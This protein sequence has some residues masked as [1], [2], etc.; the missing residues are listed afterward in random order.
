[1]GGGVY[2][3]GEIV[4]RIED[5]NMKRIR[6]TP[7]RDCILVFLVWT[8]KAHPSSSRSQWNLYPTLSTQAAS[9]QSTTYLAIPLIFPASQQISCNPI[10]L[11]RA[12]SKGPNKDADTKLIAM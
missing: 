2:S 3:E 9:Q 7:R 12:L 5:D 1:M 11:P 4:K 6:F 8:L 10:D